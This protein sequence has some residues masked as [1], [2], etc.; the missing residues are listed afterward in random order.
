MPVTIDPS[1]QQKYYKFS[2]VAIKY[3]IWIITVYEI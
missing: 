3:K 2:P 1:L